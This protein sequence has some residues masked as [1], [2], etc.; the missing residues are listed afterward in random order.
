MKNLA[1][2]VL[3]LFILSSCSS[4]ND[5]IVK[6]KFLGEWELI[7]TTGQFEGSERTGAEMEWQ[8]TY[9]LRE[10]GTF[11]KTRIRDNETDVAEGTFIIHDEDYTH[12]QSGIA[13]ISMV[14]T[15]ENNL[16]A[17]CYSD[18]LQEELIFITDELMESTWE[19]CDGLGLEYAKKSR[20]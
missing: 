6:S 11:S 17:T 8:E 5:E 15:S 3:S 18:K 13:H 4:D 14:Y 20:K 16:V 10:N 1:F 2:L 12:G 9:I 7:R 19:Q